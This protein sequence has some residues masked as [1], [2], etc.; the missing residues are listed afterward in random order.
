MDKQKMKERSLKKL[1]PRPYPNDKHAIIV[2]ISGY[3]VLLDKEDLDKV[4][5]TGTWRVVPNR[6]LYVV[7]TIYTKPLYTLFLH[8][9]I[10][11]NPQGKC[12]DH[13]NLN[14]HDN[15][16]KNLRI[17]TSSQNI[18]NQKRRIDNK[19]G[20]KGVCY[21]SD[22]NK[23]RAEI[24]I[25]KKRIHLGYFNT[26]EEAYKAYCEASKKYN[27]EYGRFV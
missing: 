11:G 2:S 21:K 17:C 23:W 26:P 4:A 7:C 5:E 13:I 19:S 10:L 15:R 16:K 8:K 22:R 6:N 20:Y 27:K 1:N 24:G 12:V 25:N 9:Y 3:D 18:C 14:T